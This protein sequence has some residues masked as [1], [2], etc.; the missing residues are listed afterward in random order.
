[1]AVVVNWWCVCDVFLRMVSIILTM[2]R[3]TLTRWCVNYPCARHYLAATFPYDWP[4]IVDPQPGSIIDYYY[5]FGDDWHCYSARLDLHYGDHYYAYSEELL[6]GGMD[7]TDLTYNPV[8][9]QTLAVLLLTMWTQYD[10][11]LVVNMQ[12]PILPPI[13]CCIQFP[14]RTDHGILLLFPNPD[15]Y[16]TLLFDDTCYSYSDEFCQPFK[17]LPLTLLIDYSVLIVIGWFIVV[18]LYTASP[19]LHA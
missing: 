4:V 15:Y 1:M 8:P 7:W 2:T 9:R 16:H 3:R 14:K 18:L 17:L 11:R 6:L 13:A 19:M 5:S 10:L 12:F